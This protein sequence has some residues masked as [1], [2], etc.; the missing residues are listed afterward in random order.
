VYA[1]EEDVI[2]EIVVRGTYANVLRSSM[3][4]KRSSELVTEAISLA[5]LGLLPDTN[6]ADALRRLPGITAS[7]DPNNGAA[8]NIQLRGMPSE[9]TLGT[10]N[11]RDVPTQSSTRDIRY[12]QFPSELIGGAVVVKSASASVNDGGVAGVIDLTTVRP[13]GSQ[14]DT[15]SIDA[16]YMTHDLSDELSRSDSG[17][18]RFSASYVAQTANDTLGV[19]IGWARRDEP[20]GVVRTQHQSYN[21]PPNNYVDIDGNGTGD[22]TAY[23]LN[24]FV[25]AGSDKRDGA[26]G[27]LQWEPNDTF[28]LYVDAMYSQFDVYNAINGF[29]VNELSALW[30]N[31]YTDF[32]VI[33]DHLIAGDVTAV[34]PFGP[35]F[36]VR[37]ENT[38]GFSDRDDNLKS[39]GINAKWNISDSSRLVFDVASSKADYIARYAQIGTQALDFS[40]GSPVVLAQQGVVFDATDELAEIAF[41]FDLADPNINRP[42]QL[43]AP[44]YEDGTDKINSA[45][46]GFEM[47]LNAWL[48]N[49]FSAGLRFVEREKTNIQLSQN[50][51]L[52]IADRQALTQD[53]ILA[54]ALG[55]YSG[56]QSN[57]PDY[58]TY[59]F[60]TVADA[61][62]GGY[63][64]TA[65][66]NDRT[67]SWVVNEDTSAAFVQFD[68]A[69]GDKLPFTGNIGVRFVDTESESSST[70][71]VLV[72]GQPSV[73][74]P[75][76][77][78][79]DYQEVLPSFSINVRPTD[80]WIIRFGF[81][82]TIS[83]APVRDLNA[84][85]GAFDFG[86]PQAFGGNPL[87]EP[88]RADQVDLS[89]EYYYGWNSF[90]SVASYYKDLETFI[91]TSTEVVDIDGT[92]Y[93]FF[94]PV[95]GS[96]GYIRGA[97]FA[98]S[99]MFDS[100]PSPFNGLGVYANLAIVD[101][102]IKV[103]RNFADPT[104]GL[105]G[106]SD[107]AYTVSAYY[108]L[109]KF[110]ANI[111]Y[112]DRD[113]Y[114]RVV[115]GGGFEVN[116]GEG[117]LS[118][119]ASYQITKGVSVFLQGLNLTDALY[120]TNLGDP[121][122]HGRYEQ[123]GRT[124]YAG[125]RASF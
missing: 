43:T 2:D 56:I 60:F 40:S 61:Y 85:F 116:E 12:D 10:M 36:G 70:R 110:D 15:F 79:N 77:V 25:R 42:F 11:G 32:V 111:S 54:P 107:Y 49:G 21:P 103:D 45:K 28:S 64:P 71:W 117:F 83:R 6:I 125:V 92:D 87:L 119:Q 53:Q 104:L 84:G 58:L 82:K 27:V 20:V 35:D 81:G 106:L 114:A 86:T 102:N 80:K 78:A 112:S 19:A 37:V 26:I 99:H 13:L 96:G 95:N 52:P 17:G 8:S 65:T 55:S 63:N 120:T 100:L 1:Q 14:L 93:E 118:L 101:S 47:D 7:R 44:F 113:D 30:T 123:F 108:N 29:N 59:D 41:N 98:I 91:T 73:L 46:I 50:V 5:D 48:F 68:F 51:T 9:L 69:G 57:V 94:R 97:E 90:I 16:R 24:H 4:Q 33:D 18:Y 39:L 121:R 66:D 76:S 3:E 31:S 109:G 34:D 122:L 89:V 124:Y 38:A 62:F 75:Y 22:V 105:L 74:E 67:A 23:G 72:A 115:D 88:F